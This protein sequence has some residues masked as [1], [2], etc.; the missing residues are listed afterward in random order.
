MCIRDSWSPSP[1]YSPWRLGVRLSGLAAHPLG[2]GLALLQGFQFL[3][4]GR[5]DLDNLHLVAQI[6][7]RKGVV[8]V[9]D[10]GRGRN[11]IDGQGIFRRKRQVG[12]EHLLPP[13]EFQVPRKYLLATLLD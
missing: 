7:A 12:W 4:G 6:V 1:F 3:W 8:R 10:H 2:A 5:A 13:L 11:F 9:H